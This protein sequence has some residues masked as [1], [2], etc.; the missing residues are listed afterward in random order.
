MNIFF[1]DNCPVKCAENL[2]T[3]RVIKMI[4][5]TAQM[6]CTAAYLTKPELFE[7]YQ[8]SNVSN[9]KIKKAYYL[10]GIKMYA[11]THVNHPSNVWLRQNRSNYEWGVQHFKA[12]SRVYLQRRGKVHKSYTQLHKVLSEFSVNLPEGEL[13]EF[14]NC[15]ANDSK[16]VNYK[17]IKDVTLAYKLYLNDRWENDK[18]EPTW[19]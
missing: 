13:T 17:H 11:T 12:L 6:L 19:E 15:A 18:I 16:G 7:V 2:D 4:L 10:N 14:A 3:K 1:T 5:E 8:Y 9:K